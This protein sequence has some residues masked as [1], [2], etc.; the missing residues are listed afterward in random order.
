[1]RLSAKIWLPLLFLIAIESPGAQQ[2]PAPLLSRRVSHFSIRKTTALDA[3][4]WFGHNERIC[5]GIEFSGPELGK[6]VRLSVHKATVSEVVKKILG[7]SDD[8]RLSVAGDVILIRKKGVK[9]PAWLFHKIP[10]FDA[11]RMELTNANNLLWMTLERNLNPSSTGGFAGDSPVTNP[12]EKVGPFHEH[13][14]TV[15]QLLIRIVNV[16]RG[17]SWFPSSNESY[18]S[19]P[20]SINHFW[21]LVFYQDANVTRPQ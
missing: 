16:S 3:L 21:T 5:F 11:P 13:G 15:E 20:A 6:S 2:N 1:M 9:P 19:F 12:V 14:R 10:Q 8:L 17:A 4:L 18:V 7:S